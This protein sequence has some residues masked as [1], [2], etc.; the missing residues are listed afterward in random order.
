[1]QKRQAVSHNRT[2]FSLSL[3][4]ASVMLGFGLFGP[5]LPIYAQLLGATLG[6]QVGFMTS[7]FMLSR[8][9]S[10]IPLGGLSDKLGRK[11]MIVIGL[12]TYG[13]ATFA[14]AIVTDWTQLVALRAVQGISA[15]MLWPSATALI[16]DEVGP[17]SRGKALG[18]FNASATA[19]LLGGPA[20]GGALQLYSRSA[21]SLSIVDS[22]RVPFYAGGLLGIISA[23][24]AM[25]LVRETRTTTGIKD[26][27]A[28]TIAPVAQKFKGTF[29]SLLGVSFAHGFSLSFLGPIIVFY[30]QHQFNLSVDETT[31]TMALAFFV[32][33]LANS[34]SQFFA[35][36]VADKWHRKSLM[37]FGVIAAQIATIAIALAQDVYAVI[38]IM[39]VRSALVASYAPALSSLQ[40]DIIPRSARGKLTG[41]MDAASNT[42]SV[43]GPLVGFALYDYVGKNTPFFATAGIFIV[44]ITLFQLTG[45]EPSVEE[46]EA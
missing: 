5:F 24:L 34:L 29:Y 10:S 12:L 1:M 43:L 14:Y 16:A 17:G 9:A 31:S 23:I 6:L 30:V 25:K 35:G 22:F 28:S 44:A 7:A 26:S 18:T 15:G 37:L 8:A 42:G 3:A 45:R 13:V 27:S 33:G 41:V 11:K 38:V 20:L 46:A 2:V 39:T 36:R 4:I 32:S 40:E 19:G 21:L